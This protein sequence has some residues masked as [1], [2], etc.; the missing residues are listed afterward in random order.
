MGQLLTRTTQRVTLAQ[1]RQVT[2]VRP[3]AAEGLVAE[4]YAQV[5]RDFGML[6]PPISLHSPAPEALAASWLMLRETLVGSG[7]LDRATKEAVAAAVSVG[8]A[9]PYCV[10]VHG[11]TLH[12]LI[13]GRDAAAIAT[14]RI[15]EVADSRLREIAGWARATALRATAS[16]QDL[17]LSPAE[18]PEAIGVVVVFHYLNRMVNIFLSDS[19]FPPGLPA[20]ARAG[21]QRLAGRMLRPISR[22]R[23]EPG[24]SLDLLPAAALPDDLSWAAGNPNIAGAFARATAAIEDAGRRS[25]PVAVR[26]LVLAELAGWDGR[27]V[28]ASRAWVDD[29]VVGL[30]VADRPTGRLALLTA[31]ASYQVDDSVVEGARSALAGD[32]ALVELTSWASLAAARQVA[33]WLPAGPRRPAQPARP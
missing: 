32:A 31:L 24:T 2:P 33:N 19:P 1:V 5:G 14:D 15:D 23:R 29:A 13:R 8:N 3:V 25:V 4:V 6:A 10:D 17:P 18:A 21:M 20:A 7:L 16:R 30:A 28:G 11:T 27:P 22:G 12:G 9:C 26:E